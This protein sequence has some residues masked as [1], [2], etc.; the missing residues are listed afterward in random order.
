MYSLRKIL[1]IT[2]ALCSFG[3]LEVIEI[4]QMFVHPIKVYIKILN[5]NFDKFTSMPIIFIKA[6][7]YIMYSIDFIS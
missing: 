2:A 5:C 1:T 3:S 7:L 6:C 4:F